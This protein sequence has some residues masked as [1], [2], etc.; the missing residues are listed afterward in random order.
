MQELQEALEAFPP[1]NK[2]SS[3]ST[4]HFSRSLPFTTNKM[5][6]VPQHEDPIY[7]SDFCFKIFGRNGN[8]WHKMFKVF[9]SCQNPLK[10]VP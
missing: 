7:G 4:V 2:F 3:F 8:R 6:F 1:V 9:F 5:K 10:A